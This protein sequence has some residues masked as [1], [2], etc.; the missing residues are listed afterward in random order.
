MDGQKFALAAAAGGIAVFVAGLLIYGLVFAS[1]MQAN[2]MAGIHR[3]AP[4]WIVL[5]V[6][7]LA[8]GTLLTTVLGYWAKVKDIPEGVRVGALLGFLVI[9]STD[10]TIAAT[11]NLFPSLR[12]A[13]VDMLASTVIMAIGGGAV[14][15][16]LTRR[17][18]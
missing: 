13:I 1:F 18:S 3:E 6:A 7:N 12:V 14:G 11:S 9:L 15:A 10:L 16:V 4:R 17:S 5:G 2:T 8:T